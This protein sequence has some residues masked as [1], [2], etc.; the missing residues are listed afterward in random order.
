MVWEYEHYMAEKHK[1]LKTKTMDESQDTSLKIFINDNG[2]RIWLI[3]PKCPL[4][5]TNLA[6]RVS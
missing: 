4:A 5:G 2:V 1:N 3:F 6:T